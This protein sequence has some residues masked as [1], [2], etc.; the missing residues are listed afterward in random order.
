MPIKIIHLGIGIYLLVCVSI[1]VVVLISTFKHGAVI[2][3]C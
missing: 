3:E 2:V 1:V